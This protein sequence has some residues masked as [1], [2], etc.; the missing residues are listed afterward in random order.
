MGRQ[1]GERGELA[2]RLRL[3]VACESVFVVRARVCAE[4]DQSCCLVL[5]WGEVRRRGMERKGSVK[6][7]GPF[8]LELEP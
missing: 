7:D 4:G 6:A 3:V 1:E 8:S 2:L 5:L